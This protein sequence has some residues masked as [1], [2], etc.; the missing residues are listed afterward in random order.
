MGV[1]ALPLERRREYQ[2][3]LV[4]EQYGGELDAEELHDLQSTLVDLELCDTRAQGSCSRSD[5]ALAMLV[6]QDKVS[7][8]DVDAV[9]R[10][11]SKLD[12]DGSGELNEMDVQAWLKAKACD[13]HEA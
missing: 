6:R 5:F 10:T 7:K 11:F 2:Q 3:R 9:L 1:A 13:R 8:A 4:L 12:I